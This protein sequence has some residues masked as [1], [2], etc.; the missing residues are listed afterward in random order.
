MNVIF[1]L[2]FGFRIC[3][4]EV[5]GLQGDSL[6]DPLGGLDSDCPAVVLLTSS[7]WLKVLD[8][9]NIPKP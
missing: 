8:R 7:A 1:A 3:F 9:E 6:P 5:L 2:L 4:Q